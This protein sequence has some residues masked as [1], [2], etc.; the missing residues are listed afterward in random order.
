MSSLPR[1]K[2][3]PA[4]LPRALVSF[5]AL[6]AIGWAAF[7][8]RSGAAR[9]GVRNGAAGARRRG[10]AHA[11]LRHP[12]PRQ[13][14]LLLCPWRGRVRPAR[15]GLGLRDAPGAARPAARRPVAAAPAAAR[16]VRQRRTPRRR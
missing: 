4:L 6:V 16:R 12:P 10:R 9:A 2:A 3:S 1:V 11:P 14:L 5:G 7:G 8:S 13:R 15:P